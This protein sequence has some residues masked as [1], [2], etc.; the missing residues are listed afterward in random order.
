MSLPPIRPQLSIALSI[1]LLGVL[2]ISSSAAAAAT[3]P[4]ARFV[5]NTI[6]SG[7]SLHHRF[8]PA[9]GGQAM[10]DPLTKPDDVT[11]LDG[12]LFVG[13]QNGVGPQGEPSD[14]GN[15]DSTVVE[16]T[17]GGQPVA[18]W[19]VAGKTDGLSVDPAI[20]ALIATVNED[21]DSSLYTIDPTA[22]A[23]SQVVHY[24]YDQALP[25][26]GGT[27]AIS[28]Y[29]GQILISASAPGT[30]GA[31]PEGAPAVYQVS[32]DASTKTATVT[33][34]FAI[35]AE[36]RTAS[37]GSTMGQQVALALTDP[38][39]NEVVPAGASRF[40]GDFVLDSQGDQEQ[41]YL[42]GASSA[43]QQLEVLSLDQSVDD[44]A[45]PTSRTGRLFSTDSIDDSVD[46]ISGPF[47]VGQAVAVATP[48]GS[49]RAPSTCPGPGFPDNFLATLNQFTGHI[50]K[51]SVTGAA[52]VPQGGLVFVR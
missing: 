22:P 15:L 3:V 12:H 23:G 34:L 52:Y 20:H 8:T 51:V 16:L 1:G 27:D 48:C 18:Q 2:G 47:E 25:H 28:V 6:L 5:V 43:H 29:R 41:I 26:N 33:S 44:T 46:V 7:T 40:G 37:R 13:F 45:W 49:N 21:A 14:D 36:A 19:D 4:K 17:T 42:A 38:D 10:S 24:Q 30:T 35:D 9:G 31:A 32:L 11:V 50:Q 39:S